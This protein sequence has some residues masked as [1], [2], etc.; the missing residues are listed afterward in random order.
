MR[1]DKELADLSLD[2]CVE[3]ENI[4]LGKSKDVKSIKELSDY[5]LKEFSIIYESFV[6]KNL[7]CKLLWILY[8]TFKTLWDKHKIATTI[9]SVSEVCR[10]IITYGTKLKS[11]AEKVEYDEGMSQFCL[12]LSRVSCTNSLAGLPRYDKY[13]L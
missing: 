8:R 6:D 4:K 13:Y 1:L 3:L 5:L 9:A 12:V 11:C 2:A 10:E 7:N